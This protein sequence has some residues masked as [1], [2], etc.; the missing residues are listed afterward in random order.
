MPKNF[1]QR[2][3]ALLLYVLLI[4]LLIL[5]VGVGIDLGWYYLNVSRL[6]NAADAAALAGAQELVKKGRTM[7]KQDYYVDGLVFAPKDIE[8]ET[9]YHS[10]NV[11][12]DGTVVAEDIEIADAKNEARFYTQKN[13]QEVMDEEKKYFV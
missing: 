6:Q 10:F 4:P 13:L 1:W 8:N 12:A 7:Y 2:G 5:A 9:K 11:E 3:Q